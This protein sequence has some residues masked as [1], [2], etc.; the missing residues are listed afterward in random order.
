MK[1]IKV[2]TIRT[3]EMT[4]L[5]ENIYR[6]INIGLVNELKTVC[7]KMSLDIFEIIDAAKT[8]PFGYQ[9]FYPGPGLGGHC[10]PIDP[11]ILS[12]KAKEFGVNTKFIELAGQ[13]NE[14]MPEFVVKNLQNALGLVNKPLNKS[15]ILILGVA[16]KKNVDDT[17]ESPALKI[18]DI[19][20]KNNVKIFYSD[21][22]VSKLKKSRKYDFNFKSVDLNKKNLSTSDA[23]VLITDHD[24]F[25]YKLIEK[26]S[27]LIIDTRGRFNLGIKKVSRS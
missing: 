3:A 1:A 17:R 18:I 25:D 8:K 10:I 19:L 15:K 14:S 6:C 16:Y 22:Y 24:D 2:S 23:T 4:K 26:H 9:A 27:K 20:I 13:I 21:P 11:Y 7:E 5:L 12:W